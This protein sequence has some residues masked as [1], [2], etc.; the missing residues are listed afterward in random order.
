ML[1]IRMGILEMPAA[2]RG[3]SGPP[4]L[5]RLSQCLLCGALVWSRSGSE[6]DCRCANGG[7]AKD[8]ARRPEFAASTP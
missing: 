6:P 7:I 1:P 4:E 5:E 2:S 3:Q 8:V